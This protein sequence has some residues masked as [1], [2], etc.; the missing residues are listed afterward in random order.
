M[1]KEQVLAFKKEL[2][3]KN[4]KQLTSACGMIVANGK[5]KCR[6]GCSSRWGEVMAK[7]SQCD[8][9]CVASYAAFETKCRAKAESLE[10]VYSMKMKMA[11]SRETCYEGHCP[12][13]PQVWMKADEAAMNAEVDSQCA[14]QCTAERIQTRCDNR[15]QLEV[16]FLRGSI[17]RAC[18]D[19][20]TVT[21]CFETKKAATST[22]HDTCMS[23]DK[24]T[25]DTQYADCTS[26]GNTDATFKQAK[27]FCDKR[28]EMCNE[29]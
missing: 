23:T 27:E 4:V 5:G 18:H 12:G 28:K 20:S 29:Q 22:A 10:R 14:K 7:R 24:A 9:K 1:T 8:A 13:I 11:E 19:S 21:A 3:S 6:Q 15:Y 17:E 26:K 2:R 16:D 25:C